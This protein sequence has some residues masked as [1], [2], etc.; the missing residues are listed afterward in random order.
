MDVHTSRTCDHLVEVGTEETIAATDV[1]AHELIKD[2]TEVATDEVLKQTV[3]EFVENLMER[4]VCVCVNFVQKI[5]F[6]S[7]IHMNFGLVDLYIAITIII[8]L[9]LPFSV[10]SGMD[11]ESSPAAILPVDQSSML[12]T[13]STVH[14]PGISTAESELSESTVESSVTEFYSCVSESVIPTDTSHFCSLT[15]FSSTEEPRGTEDRNEAFLTPQQS[16]AEPSVT[17]SLPELATAC[18]DDVSSFSLNE[19]GD[20]HCTSSSSDISDGTQLKSTQC[21]GQS[22]TG[23]DQRSE[24][25][26]FQV[27][28]VR[29]MVGLGLTLGSDDL[30]EVAI[31]KIGTLSSAA[32]Q[33]EL[34]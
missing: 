20:E 2:G 24:C 17:L 23:L 27:K 30:K 25:R 3:T 19:T 28:L 29:G 13:Q 8:I 12:D 22:N 10:L 26:V 16:C 14:G 5:I 9:S 21:C 33:G 11:N 15:S 18:P 34:G 7:D 4:C 32:V 1:A 31:K 6:L